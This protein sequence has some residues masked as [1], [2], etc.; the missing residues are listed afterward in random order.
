MAVG[1]VDQVTG[2]GFRKFH[3]ECHVAQSCPGDDEAGLLIQDS[4]AGFP[5][6]LQHPDH[7]G[8]QNH[9]VIHHLNGFRCISNGEA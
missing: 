1:P 9:P 8:L 5:E 4:L 7:I 6:G 3:P 2:F